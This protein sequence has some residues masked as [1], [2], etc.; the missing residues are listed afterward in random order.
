M[1]YC[2][3]GKLWIHVWYMCVCALARVLCVRAD[4]HVYTCVRVYTHKCMYV[5]VCVCMS[6]C[7]SICARVYLRACTVVFERVYLFIM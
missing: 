7:V 3:F 4:G 2:S 1:P 5:C 6:V